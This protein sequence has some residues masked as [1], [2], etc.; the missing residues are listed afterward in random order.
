M[1]YPAVTGAVRLTTGKI[2]GP[3]FHD[4]Q[5]NVSR[6]GTAFTSTG[7]SFIDD[8]IENK[9]FEI[10][11]G[12]MINNALH[13]FHD[14]A[15]AEGIAAPPSL[16]IL[17]NGK[18]TRGFASM[19]RQMGESDFLDAVSSGFINADTGNDLVNV[20]RFAG[21]L[22]GRVV[23]DLTFPISYPAMRTYVG[24]VTI[25]ADFFNSDEIKR[26]AYHELG[27][28]S[29]FQTAGEDYWQDVIRSVVKVG[30]HGNEF[31]PDA[32][33]ISL[34][35]SWP[36]HLA[37]SILAERY[38]GAALFNLPSSGDLFLSWNDRLEFIHNES[39]NHVAIGVYNDLIDPRRGVNGLER[40]FDENVNAAV[41]VGN[42]T[43]TDARFFFR[44]N[45]RDEVTGFSNQLI[46][47]NLTSSTRSIADLNTIMIANPM[48]NNPLEIQALFNDY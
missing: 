38:G 47:Q 18:Q 35:E 30:G 26:L 27:H 41:G 3:V 33:F 43:E 17:V 1:G 7:V 22:L 31:G 4:I 39:A 16:N 15:A 6:R 37:L 40:T 44:R 28:T 20:L 21:G 9:I 32:D 11:S 29:H 5:V 34:F 13:E 12:C 25:G 42:I 19:L 36:E 14:F 45:V 46:G 23:T 8:I 2:A 10:W 48:G 24:D